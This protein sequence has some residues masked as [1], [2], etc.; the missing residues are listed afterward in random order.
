MTAIVDVTDEQMQRA[1]LHVADQA[2][3]LGATHEELQDILGAIGYYEHPLRSTLRPSTWT[4][5][6]RHPSVLLQL[7]GAR[8]G[9]QEG[10]PEM[11]R[12]TT[13]GEIHEMTEENVGHAPNGRRFCK[14]C[15][16]LAWERAEAS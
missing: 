15:N 9:T 8:S 2:R 3:R 13:P 7:V 4:S 14:A 5:G 11:C 10:Q 12:S 1:A 16:L 6:T